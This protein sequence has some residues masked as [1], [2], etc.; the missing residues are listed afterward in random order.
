[1]KYVWKNGLLGLGTSVNMLVVPLSKMDETSSLALGGLVTV[2]SHTDGSIHQLYE[3]SLSLFIMMVTCHVSR[4]T[5]T[6]YLL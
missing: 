4:K 6:V 3:H 5:A 2:Y 1:V